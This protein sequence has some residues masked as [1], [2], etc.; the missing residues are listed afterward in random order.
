MNVNNPIEHNKQEKNFILLIL[1]TIEHSSYFKNTK[2][3][4]DCFMRLDFIISQ[5]I[6]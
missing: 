3:L 1:Q 4:I 2:N 5:K 6:G